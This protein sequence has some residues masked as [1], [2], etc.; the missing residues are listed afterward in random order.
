MAEKIRT[1]IIDDDVNFC[2]S[3]ANILEASG[4]EVK[5]AN[6]GFQGMDWLRRREFD[7]VLMDI[8]MPHVDG[9][10]TYGQMKA[11]RPDVKAVLMSAYYGEGVAEKAKSDGV[12]AMLTKPLDIDKLIKIISS[13]KRRDHQGEI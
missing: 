12:M 8:K 11:L 10:K 6:S 4:C 5:T 9:L 13:V 7:I 2:K 1:L 3:L